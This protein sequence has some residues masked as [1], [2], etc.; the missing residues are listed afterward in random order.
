MKAGCRGFF[1]AGMSS[2]SIISIGASAQSQIGCSDLSGMQPGE[3]VCLDNFMTTPDL[4]WRSIGQVNFR[5][6]IPVDDNGIPLFVP[7]QTGGPNASGDNA[8]FVGQGFHSYYGDRLGYEASGL[9]DVD[10]DGYNDWSTTWYDAAPVDQL[11]NTPR[12]PADAYVIPVHSSLDTDPNFAHTAANLATRD[13]WTKVG[14][15]RVFSGRDG[16]QIGQ[17]IWSHRNN[18]IAPHEINPIKDIDGD[19]RDELVLSA[20]TYNGTRGGVYVMAYSNK[21]NTDPGDTTERW[22]CILHIAGINGQSEFAYELEDT[23]SDFNGDGQVDIVAAST[24]WRV[25]GPRSVVVNE[26]LTY[27]YTTG[28]G[29]VFLTPPVD[30]FTSIQN[31]Q[32]WETDPLRNNVKQPL[33]LIAEEDYNLCVMQLEDDGNGGLA[34][35]DV[36]QDDPTNSNGLRLGSI[37][38]I[39]DVGDIDGDMMDDFAVFGG[40]RYTVP[41]FGTQID[42]GAVYFLLS[43][44]G[45]GGGAEP[46]SFA[47]K[48]A[49][50]IGIE[51]VNGIDVPYEDPHFVAVAVDVYQDAEVV[52]HG[53][54]QRQ[55]HNNQRS[56]FRRNFDGVGE[57]DMA[58]VTYQ[59]SGGVGEI[60]ILLDD[61]NGSRFDPNGSIGINIPTSYSNRPHALRYDDPVL[62][63][64][65][66]IRANSLYASDGV[67]LLSLGNISGVWVAEDYN[68]DGNAELSV[69]NTRGYNLGTTD[70]NFS[71]IT[72]ASIMDIPADPMV[73]PTVIRSIQHETPIWHDAQHM[74]TGS[75]YGDTGMHFR[76]LRAESASDLDY[77]GRADVLLATAATPQ[78]VLWAPDPNGSNVPVHIYDE[79][80]GNLVANYRPYYNSGQDDGAG[81]T[82]ILLSPPNEPEYISGVTRFALSPEGDPRV[83]VS[84]S[85]DKISPQ[86][87]DVT[88]PMDGDTFKRPIDHNVFTID[89]VDSPE[90]VPA[91]G[92]TLTGVESILLTPGNDVAPRRFVI[93]FDADLY[94]TSP[95]QWY[96]RFHTRWLNESLNGGPEHWWIVEMPPVWGPQPGTLGGS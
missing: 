62:A 5:T 96:I 72:T 84:L 73:K 65:H 76:G 57:T 39:A 30:V 51:D 55:Y 20:N 2:I 22:V 35:I 69:G 11:T 83:R 58:L 46:Y 29:W 28:A 14:F 23:Q 32:T 77:D 16:S 42:T 18:A 13:T 87:S 27:N 43:S 75:I 24:F 81:S 1:L 40:Y 54:E 95:T 12:V 78:K 4:I 49:R 92:A 52:F 82:H 50:I 7:I 8:N 10:G 44:D 64:E 31:S 19:G 86:L 59:T 91:S 80:D 33:E 3:F 90:G 36:F 71:L 89:I 74:L 38:D 34:P 15:A 26:N 48:Q 79:T 88:P 9:F 21:Y 6:T 67:T 17:E 60:D 25:S 63:P 93:E 37:G 94:P 85:V 53:D 45:F 70:P 68:G 41:G 56:Y 61:P 47:G 66:Q